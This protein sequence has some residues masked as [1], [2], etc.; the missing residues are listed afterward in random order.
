MSI[1]PFGVHH[2]RLQRLLFFRVRREG[3]EGWKGGI[4]APCQNDKL[5]ANDSVRRHSAGLSLR[6]KQETDTWE[7]RQGRV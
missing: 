1:I 4:W 5:L 3:E 2:A 6:N 7:T